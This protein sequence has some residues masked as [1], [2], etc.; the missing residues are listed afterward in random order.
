LIFAQKG[1]G[2][3]CEWIV[4]QKK[5]ENEES[6]NKGKKIIVIKLKILNKKRG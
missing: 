1:R 4:A 6:K 3:K 2:D 5:R